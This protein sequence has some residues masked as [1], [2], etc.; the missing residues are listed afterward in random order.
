MSEAD[1]LQLAIGT[2]RRRPRVPSNLPGLDRWNDCTRRE[3]EAESTI[4]DASSFLDVWTAVRECGGNGWNWPMLT[5]RWARSPVSERR[6]SPQWAQT[7]RIRASS[8]I[9]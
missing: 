7:I 8:H 1:F 4:T 9:T 2:T 6:P 5:L 3:I